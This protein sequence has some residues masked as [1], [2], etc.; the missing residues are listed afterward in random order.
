MTIGVLWEFFEFSMDRLFHMDMQKD[1]IVHTIS[2]V[3]L[4]PTNS[5]I[6][7][8]ID[9]ITSVAVNGQDLG[10]SGYLDIG[11]YDT[12]EDLFVNFI[13]ATVFSVIGYFYLKRRGGGRFAAAFIPTL[14]ETEKEADADYGNS[15]AQTSDPDIS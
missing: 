14:E 8:T 1:T 13:G 6:P 3:M 4:D 5:N 9:G 12:M 11:L 7:I 10:F 2:S 15:P